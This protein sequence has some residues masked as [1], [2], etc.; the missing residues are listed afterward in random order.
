MITNV[1][2]YHQLVAQIR[3]KGLTPKRKVIYIRVSHSKTKTKHKV[4][5]MSMRKKKKKTIKLLKIMF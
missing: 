3:T 2:V 1:S 5:V 4:P